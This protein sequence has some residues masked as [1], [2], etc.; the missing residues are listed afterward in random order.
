MID[1]QAMAEPWLLAVSTLELSGSEAK[2]RYGKR[3]TCE[4]SF[5]D[6][7]NLR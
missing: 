2:R 6:L 7:K 3:F 4:E 1:D 5:R